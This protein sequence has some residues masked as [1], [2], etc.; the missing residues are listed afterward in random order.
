MIFIIFFS[1]FWALEIIKIITDSRRMD[2]TISCPNTSNSET[3]V[4]G[5]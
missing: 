3:Q 5:L 1:N 2:Q 4:R